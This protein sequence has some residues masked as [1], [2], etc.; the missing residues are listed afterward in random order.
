M[1]TRAAS[2]TS[3]RKVKQEL[4]RLLFAGKGGVGTTKTTCP[5]VLDYSRYSYAE[6]K[7]AYLEKVHTLHPDR[8]H[9]KAQSAS[10]REDAKTKFVELQ[11]AW[12]KYEDIAK[13][14][15]RVRNGSG[16]AAGQQ[17]EE[18]SFTMFGVGCSFSDNDAERDLRNEITDQACRGW[19]SSGAL[20]DGGSYRQAEHNS[21]NAGRNTSRSVSLSDDDM[22][23]HQDDFTSNEKEEEPYAN[24]SKKEHA[25]EKPNHRPSLVSHLLDGRRKKYATTTVQRRA[26]SQSPKAFK[27]DGNDERDLGLDVEDS[28]SQFANL[29]HG[30]SMRTGFPEAVFAEGKT[31]EQVA[32]ILDDM[33]RNVNESCATSIK[34][35]GGNT[36]TAILATR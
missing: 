15:R 23:V 33:A 5:G 8:S 22:F 31:P 9:G 21:T 24:V 20:D 17:P 32:S 16:G 13:T 19:F 28:L 3:S 25:S 6:L 35:G 18:P 12:Q 2:A 4:V 26:Y 1:S 7:S 29:D 11:Q 36:S 34:G 14:M 10:E 30:R 27:E